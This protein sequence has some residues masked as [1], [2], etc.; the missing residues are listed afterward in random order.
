[1]LAWA[2]KNPVP[3]GVSLLLHGV[4]LAAMLWAMPSPK[5]SKNEV[6]K[7]PYV[8]AKLVKLEAQAKPKKSLA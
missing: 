3:L 1:M 5:P 8:S 6:K 2:L 7:I 4:L